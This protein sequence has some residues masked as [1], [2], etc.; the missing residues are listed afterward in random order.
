M[1]N[2]KLTVAEALA[3]VNLIE[4]TLDAFEQ[5]APETVAA[6]GGRDA[7]A[8]CSEMT[9]IGP[10]PRLDAEAWE[11]MSR[12]YEERREHASINRGSYA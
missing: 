5:T 1:T 10:M 7:L 8:K 6:M 2:E 3:K 11:V 12:E 9:C 4:A